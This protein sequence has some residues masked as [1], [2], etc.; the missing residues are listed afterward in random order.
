MI[1]VPFLFVFI[2]LV[3]G[4]VE[5]TGN[6]EFA[7]CLTDKGVKMYGTEWCQHCK[8]Q[9]E[10]FGDSFKFVDY[11]DCDGNKDECTAAGI[12]GY[13]TWIINGEQYAGE[14]KLSK[15]AELSECEL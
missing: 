2:I 13:P 6:P 14:Q 10:L 4:C 3:S 11:V 7:Q 12:R 9:K 5:K 8:N 1:M 15:L